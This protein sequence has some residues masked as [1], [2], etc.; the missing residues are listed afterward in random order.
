MDE[1]GQGFGFASFEETQGGPADACIMG[2]G[3]P[4]LVLSQ[5]VMPDKPADWAERNLSLMA[6]QFMTDLSFTK[7]DDS[8]L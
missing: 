6:G 5:P 2:Q 3:V 7:S 8:H 1:R 4:G